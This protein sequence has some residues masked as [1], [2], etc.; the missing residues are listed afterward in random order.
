MVTAASTSDRT[1]EADLAELRSRKDEWAA[2]SLPERIKLLDGV[3]RR[4]DFAAGRWVEASS[5]AKG[6]DSDSGMAGEEWLAG[7]YGVL[8]AAGALRKSLER[9]NRGLNTYKR[10]WVSAGPDGRAIVRVLP[11]EWWEPLLLSGYRLDVTMRSGVTPV[12]L[13]DHTAKLY[14]NPL[15]TGRVSRSSAPAISPRS[16]RLT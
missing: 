5:A 2:V 9:L 14:R 11:V 15:T 12:N 3:I 7:P 1:L 16:R 13:S 4:A 8:V 6:F 10:T